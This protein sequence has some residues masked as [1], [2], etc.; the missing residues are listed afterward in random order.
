MAQL[1]SM[2]LDEIP[3][4]FFAD[5]QVVVIPQGRVPL[6]EDPATWARAVFDLGSGPWWVRAVLALRRPVA[7]VLRIPKDDGEVFAVAEVADGEALIRGDAV[8]LDFRVGVAADL[9]RRLLRVVTAVR[10]HGWRGRL[11]FAPV[12]IAH[13]PLTR[14]IAAHAARR[15]ARGGRRRLPRLW[16]AGWPARRRGAGVS[17]GG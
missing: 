17:A 11:Y 13:G 3:Q 9:D 6:P 5:V 10:V 12:S 7:A 16:P 4:P 2:A 8:H 15:V 1:T 14:V